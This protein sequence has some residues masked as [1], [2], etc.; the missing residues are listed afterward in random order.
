[1]IF[2]QVPSLGMEANAILAECSIGSSQYIT[3]SD[4]LDAVNDGETIKINTNISSD[5][6]V[7]IDK[8]VNFDLNGYVLDV[9][10]TTQGGIG[11]EVG[12]GGEVTIDDSVIGSSFDISNCSVGVQA[13]NGGKATV[14]SISNTDVYIQ[15]DNIEKSKIESD[16][17]IPTTKPYYFTYSDENDNSVWV[18]VMECIVDGCTTLPEDGGF[19]GYS[20]IDGEKFYHINNAKQLAH[21]SDHLDL[22][23]IQMADIDLSEDFADGW[24]PIGGYDYDMNNSYDFGY[25]KGNYY[26]QNHIIEHLY[27]T[28]DTSISHIYLGLFSRFSGENSIIKDLT[29]KIDGV[30]TTCAGSARFGGIVGAI[31]DGSIDNCHSIYYGDVIT[32]CPNGSTGGIAGGSWY[33]SIEDST[34]SFIEGSILTDGW[35]KYAG[36]IVGQTSSSLMNCHVSISENEKI[37]A[38]HVGGI[39]GTVGKLKSYEKV[40]EDCSVTGNGSL[41]IFPQR[42][43][44][45]AIGGIAGSVYESEIIN[46]QNSV[47]INADISKIN[48]GCSSYAGG[49][50]GYMG[51]NSDISKSKNTGNVYLEIADNVVDN[52]DDSTS[53]EGNEYAYVGGIAGYIN[54]YSRASSIRNCENDGNISSIN[55][56]PTLRAYAGGIVGHIDSGDGD[57]A[58]ITISSC[59]N[60]NDNLVYSEAST[61]LTGGLFGS[62]SYTNFESPNI[63]ISNCYN[64]SRVMS[65]SNGPA[66]SDTICVGITAGGTIGCAGEVTIENTYSTASDISAINNNEGDAYEG[67]IAAMIY[68]T[69]MIQNY[70]ESN[71]NVNNAVGSKVNGMDLDYEA[72]LANEYSGASQSQLQTKSFYGDNWKWYV[73]GGSSPNYCDDDNPWRFTSLNSYAKLRGAPYIEPVTPPPSSSSGS[74][75]PSIKVTVEDMGIETNVKT[76]I[77]P[78]PSNGLAKIRISTSVVDALIKKAKSENALSRKDSLEIELNP[79]SDISNMEVDIRQTQLQKIVDDTDCSFKISSPLISIVFDEK[80]L[81]TINDA[82]SGGTIKIT[83]GM[84]DK[85]LLT[86]SES[87]KVK[88]RPLYDLNVMTGDVNITSFKGG[89]ATVTIPYVLGKDENPHALVV[90]YLGTDG[91]LKSVKGHYDEELASVVFTTHHFSKFI[92][93]YNPVIFDDVTEDEWFKDAVDFISARGIAKGTGNGN[94]SPKDKLTRGQFIVM[95]MNAFENDLESLARNTVNQFEDAGDMYY[96]DYLLDAKALG[97]STGIGNNMFGPDIEISRQEMFTMIYNTLVKIDELPDDMTESVLEDFEDMKAIADWA[98]TAMREL[99]ELGVVEGSDNSLNPNTISTRAEMTKILFNL[100]NK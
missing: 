13:Y 46:C 25:F 97:I 1:M 99:V 16:L 62:T 75:S 35:S 32:N 6:I 61:T 26:G 71:E 41:E 19:T 81:G 18:K 30:E 45:V 24:I 47:D 85:S 84:A 28:Y 67:G 54:G 72:D 76:V 22:N 89:S 5:G 3:L 21:I 55:N 77:K 60:I 82:N 90:Y 51:S 94:F 91:S 80:A 4:A 31:Q 40:F 68:N 38:P 65:K 86:E 49:I 48:D 20:I 96:T 2:S 36:G 98:E 79:S 14:S 93:E 9:Q 100:L 50:V 92:V 56:I 44:R 69:T 70:Y 83:A 10:N 23:Y 8:S 57:N 43:Y 34:A 64:E 58:G 15:L 74:S 29:V 39:A 27:L 73:S 52:Y 88:D 11:L 78:N 17:T 66:A 63:V 12:N 33:G 59:A 87:K 42:Y 37:K 53:P 95:L 7:V